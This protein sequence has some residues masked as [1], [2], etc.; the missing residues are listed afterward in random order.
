MAR[1]NQSNH[2]G[3]YWLTNATWTQRS[4][5]D[6][7]FCFGSLTKLAQTVTS[8]DCQL[9]NPF[10]HILDPRAHIEDPMIDGMDVMKYIN[11]SLSSLIDVLFAL[12]D[13]KIGDHIH[14]RNSKLTYLL[15]PC[16]GGDSKTLIFVNVSP[17]PSSVSESF[18]SL[19]F[20]AKVNSD[21]VSVMKYINKSLS[22]LIDVLFALKDSKI[23]DHIHFRNSKLTYL[24][25]ANVVADA[26]SCKERI[27]PLW[28]RALVMTIG[29]DL[30]K[31][32]LEDQIE[33]LKPE[34]LKNED[35][36]GMIRKDIPKEKLEPRADRT[37]CLNGRMLDVCEGQGRTSKAIGI[38]TPY[39]AL[40]G[41]KC[42]S[43]VCWAEVGEAQLTGPEMIQET[44]E[45]IVLIK[46]RIQAA[47]DRQKSYTDLKL[48]LPQELSRVHHTFHVSNLKKCYADEPLAMPLEGIHVDD[49]L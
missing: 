13:S 35:V 40:Y 8:K 4:T 25:Q 32:I 39:E 48:E 27:E 7:D 5:R 22:S 24:L 47:Q 38:A 26:L 31:Q 15:Q 42:R 6:D 21:T 2:G 19:R 3:S 1:T 11:K 46:Q 20:A 49:K 43:P 14:F 36:C 30:P 45:K 33:V 16:L 23:G 12:K 41:R 28:V 37:L 29:L 9:G 34:N 44:T 17:D 10:V 18:R